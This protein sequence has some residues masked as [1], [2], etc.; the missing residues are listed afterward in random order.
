M[1][2]TTDQNRVRL[3]LSTGEI[4][5][6]SGFGASIESGGEVVFNTAMSGYQESLTD[7]SYT[8]QILVQTAAMIGNTGMNN[9]DME[10]R[11]IQVSGMIVHE[12]VD[13][14]SNYRATQS[15]HSQLKAAGVP[16]L[17]GVDTRVLTTLLRSGGAVQGVISGDQSQ[18]D[19]QLVQRAR[20][21]DSMVGSDFASGAG[22]T[23]VDSWN[24]HSGKWV[25]LSGGSDHSAIPVGVIDCGVKDNILRCLVD[26]GCDPKVLPMKTSASTIKDMLLDGSIYGVFLSNGPGDPE[27]LSGLVSMVRE[28]VHD[29]E[30]ESFPIYGICLG[31]QVLA[32]AHGAKTFKLKFGHRG[33]NHPILEPSSGHVSI[34]SQN[35]GFAVDEKS[36]EGTELVITHRHLNDQTVAGIERNDRSIAGMQYHPEASPGPHDA[37]VFFERFSAE[38]SKAYSGPERSHL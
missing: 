37:G 23:V 29:N 17:S 3:A 15:L 36:C 21:G 11:G 8:G 1:T 32:L 30:I 12:Y 31:H 34:T 18:T 22:T 10:S 35:H 33:I 7:P 25:H 16:G 13:S 27:A 4:F 19:A 9:L 28:L 24:Q 2:S 38:V 6:G 26:V 5:E 20:S 14:H